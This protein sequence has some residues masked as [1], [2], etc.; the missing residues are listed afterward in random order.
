MAYRYRAK[1][2]QRVQRDRLIIC[3]EAYGR[4]RVRMRRDESMQARGRGH[5]AAVIAAAGRGTRMDLDINKQYIEIHGMPILAMTISKFEECSFIDEI[6]V[7]ANKDEIDY[8]RKNVIERF[9]FTKVRSV[10]EG[11]DSRQRSVYNGLKQVSAGCGIV[12]IHDGAR[13]FVSNDSIIE[14]IEAAGKYGAACVAVPA[15][16]TIKESDADGFVIRTLD[17]SSLWQ[18]QT[19]QAFAYEMIMDAHSRAA[20][21]MFEATDDAMLAEKYG[22][23]VRLVMGGYSNIKV[24]TKEDLAFAEVLFRRQHGN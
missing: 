24:T 13:P 2:C 5:V 11:G 19:P 10:T 8:C 16:D 14:C 4:C 15:K 9:G 18:I 21:D 1:V 20:R 7:V 23:R 22:H 6:I 17:R 3:K 12:L